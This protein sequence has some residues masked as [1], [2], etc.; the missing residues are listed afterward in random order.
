MACVTMAA[1]TIPARRPSAGAVPGRWGACLAVRTPPA[2]L[3]PGIRI[4]KP[5]PRPSRSLL[6]LFDAQQFRG[7]RPEV[8]NRLPDRIA[9]TNAP[10]AVDL[11][12]RLV[13]PAAG[14]RF[15][16]VSFLLRQLLFV[17]QFPMGDG[18]HD[19]LAAVAALLQFAGL[20]QGLDAGLPVSRPVLDPS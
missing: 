4:A 19:P 20:L 10:V 13:V 18:H 14:F 3:L 11:F 8:P 1:A 12:Y 6:F 9:W 2:A 7:F 15:V 5:R 17:C 16:P